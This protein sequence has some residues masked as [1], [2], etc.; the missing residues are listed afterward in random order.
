M[1]SELHFAWKHSISLIHQTKR[2]FQRTVLNPV[3]LIKQ[4]RVYFQ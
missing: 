4:I 1:I 2:I 3:K